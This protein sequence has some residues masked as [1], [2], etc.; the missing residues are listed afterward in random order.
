[1]VQMVSGF[2]TLVGGCGSA[3]PRPSN[4]SAE[5]IRHLAQRGLQVN[6]LNV[7]PLVS[8]ALNFYREV[9]FFGLSSEPRSDMLLYQWGVYNWGKGENFEFDITRQFIEGNAHDDEA[10]SQMRLTAYFEPKPSLRNISAGNRWCESLA[11][12]PEFERFV[13]SSA[14]Y[15][16]ARQLT[17]SK[18]ELSW[19]KV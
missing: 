13:L 18:I 4:S 3:P 1:M 15:N 7:D 5:M 12:V 6:N 2:A 8:S 9:R 17:P 19:G 10:I 16:S 11:E 14:A